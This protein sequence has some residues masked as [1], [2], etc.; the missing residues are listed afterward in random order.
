MKPERWGLS[1][2]AGALRALLH[3]L[4]LPRRSGPIPLGTALVLALTTVFAPFP[5]VAAPEVA[6]LQLDQ[7]DFN[8]SDSPEPPPDSAAWQRQRLPDNWLL[9]R[10]G[11]QGYGWYRFQV[12][13]P[14]DPG[15]PYAVYVPVLKTAASL[16]VNG[17]AAGQSGI[18]VRSNDQSFPPYLTK[19][20]PVLLAHPPQMFPIPDGLLHAGLNTIHLRLRVEDGTLGVLSGMTAGPEAT[21][22][23]LYTWRFLLTVTGPQMVVVF[24]AGFGLFIL[25]LWLRRR[26][27]TMYGYAALT[28]LAFAVFV[29]G[30]YVIAEPPLPDPWWGVVV[31]TALESYITLMCFFSLRY[32]G[33][34]RPVLERWL[35]AYLAVSPLLNL[36]S[37]LGIGGWAVQQWWLM[38]FVLTLVYV[39]IFWSVAWQRK[40]LETLGL[41]A[42]ATFKLIIS[43][44]ERLLPYPFD[45]PRYQPFAYLPIFM[46]I[47][48]ILIDRF[49]RCS[50]N[51]R[52]STPSS[53]SAW[54]KNMP[55][56]RATT[57]ACRPWS[58]SRPSSRSAR[59]SCATCTMASAH[60]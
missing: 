18:V 49:V 28:A 5:S 37:Y 39:A 6:L 3:A 40:T 44:N 51:R 2:F 31:W 15:E 48:W 34:C 33:W 50:T 41:A 30:R 29:A 46:M 52:N 7:A 55:N 53:N 27:E 10:P 36:A 54:R 25:L 45:L 22:R 1:R 11:V 56:W 19:A 13:L 58:A 26:H 12:V 42:A 60:T 32:A 8:L 24:S 16:L 4:T 9:S 21:V 59:A 38:T 23:T 14:A 43:A 57:S 47:G 20:P 17:A 35:W